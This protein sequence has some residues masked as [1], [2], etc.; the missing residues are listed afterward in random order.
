L[1]AADKTDNFEEL[2]RARGS[3]KNVEI[4]W[5]DDGRQA[6]DKTGVVA[7]DLVID[8][9]HGGETNGLKW[10]RPL[11]GLNAFIHTAAVSGQP[12]DV[13]HQASEG[14]GILP[15]LPPRRGKFE[16]W[17]LLKTLN[18]LIVDLGMVMRPRRD[19]SNL[20]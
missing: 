20:P 3:V 15:H 17:H 7:P 19:A 16:A 4:S 14:V 6:L 11:V 8:D 2:A 18:P 12:Q 5:G 13:F 1:I 9:G 10:I